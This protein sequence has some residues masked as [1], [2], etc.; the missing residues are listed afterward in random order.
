MTIV[1]VFEQ[2]L[3]LDDVRVEDGGQAKIIQI[4]GVGPHGEPD[5]GLPLFLRLHSYAE[6]GD[7]TDHAEFDGMIGKRVRV[8]IEIIDEST[9]TGGLAQVLDEK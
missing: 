6:D 4:D 9:L 7:G 5:D 2:V 3:T 8:T 1:R